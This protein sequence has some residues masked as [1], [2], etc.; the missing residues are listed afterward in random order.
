MAVRR[1]ESRIRKSTDADLR[2]IHT[3]LVDQDAR[4]IPGTFLCN[5]EV[6][7]EMHK[8]GK[9]LTYIDGPSGQSVAYQWGS[10]VR[11]GILEVRHDM[12]GKGIGRK[13]VEHRIKQAIKSNE[14]FLVIQCKHGLQQAAFVHIIRHT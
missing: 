5:W 7:K 1:G 4:N 8:K 10:L 12:R 3:W 2:A 9:L 13:L 6:T 11:P 14:C